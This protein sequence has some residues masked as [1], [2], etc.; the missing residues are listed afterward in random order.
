[1]GDGEAV[2]HLA[3]KERRDGDCRLEVYF[4]SRPVMNEGQL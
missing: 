2:Q 1:M 4:F 3:S